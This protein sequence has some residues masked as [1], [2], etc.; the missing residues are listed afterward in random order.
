MPDSDREAVN[1]HLARHILRF[2]FSWGES[3]SEL[4]RRTKA[5]GMEQ[6]RAVRMAMAVLGI[7]CEP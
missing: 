4:Q 7:P 5:D 3:A 1:P 2:L 6:E